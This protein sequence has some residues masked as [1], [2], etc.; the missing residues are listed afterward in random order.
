MPSQHD[1]DET[2]LTVRVPPVD[3]EAALAVLKREQWDMRAAVVALLNWLA[4][5]PRAALAALAPY[6]PAPKPPAGRGRPRRR[7]EPES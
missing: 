4:D 2:G 6:R 1:P 3:K 7:A 5:D